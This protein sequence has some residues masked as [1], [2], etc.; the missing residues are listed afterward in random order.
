MIVESL[1]RGIALTIAGSDSGGGAGIQ[2]DLKTFAALRLFGTTVITAITAQNSLTVSDIENLPPRI[3]AAQMD[4]VLSDFPVNAA[5]TGMLSCEETILCVC[6]GI[7]RHGITRL[8]VDPVMIAQSGASL[9]DAEAVAAIRQ[10][11]LPL[12]LL[13]TPNIPEAERLSGGPVKSVDDMAS[14]ARII[15]GFGPKTVLVKGGHMIE[16]DVVTDILFANGAITRFDSP[17]I[18]TENTHGTG[19]TLS[20]AIAAELA[21]GSELPEAVRKGRQYLM[22]AL[23]RSFRP[24]HGAGP[25][26]HAVLAPWLS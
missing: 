9:I 12:A 23:K 2:A 3:V 1:Y 5:K 13:V 14:A 17:R 10:E 26:G 6:D 15:A 11:L 25:L 8:V 18:P 4:A 22:L 19:C 20:A 7:R 24:G 21:A 16:G